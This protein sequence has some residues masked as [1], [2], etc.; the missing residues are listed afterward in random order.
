MCVCIL[1]ENKKRTAAFTKFTISLHYYI[2]IT[3]QCVLIYILKCL[4]AFTDLTIYTCI[5]DIKYHILYSNLFCDTYVLQYIFYLIMFQ[6]IYSKRSVQ[7][8]S[9]TLSILDIIISH[10]F[11]SEYIF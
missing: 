6:Y 7:L 10:I 3:F 1:S 5:I 9:Q 11:Y 4:P 2:Y 8:P